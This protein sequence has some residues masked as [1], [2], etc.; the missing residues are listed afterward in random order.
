[1]KEEEERRI[2]KGIEDRREEGK[3]ERKREQKIDWER[4]IGK[5]KR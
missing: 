3:E 2:V 5:G 4:N 1:M